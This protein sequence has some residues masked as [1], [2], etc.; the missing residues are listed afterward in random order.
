MRRFTFGVL[1]IATLASLLTTVEASALPSGS[2]RS[3]DAQAGVNL[4]GK[5]SDDGKT[6]TADDDNKWT[7]SNAAALK[8]HERRYVTVK[9]R[10][11]LDNR[12]IQ[13]LSVNQDRTEVRHGGDSAFRR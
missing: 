4:S 1:T 5:V 9:C 12:A 3:A 10:M 2:T 6:F 7:V 8:G 13:V 11:D